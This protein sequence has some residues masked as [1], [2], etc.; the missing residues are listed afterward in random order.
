MRKIKNVHLQKYY[1]R[2]KENINKN[3]V[4]YFTM[5][6]AQTCNVSCEVICGRTVTRA[7]ESSILE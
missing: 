2:V 7:A 6:G 3:Y 5:N 4:L 1:R